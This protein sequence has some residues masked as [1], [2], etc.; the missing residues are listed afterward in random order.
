MENALRAWSDCAADLVAV[1]AGRQPADLVI[2][3]GQ[4]ANVH[5]R[6][7]L[8]WDVAIAADRKSVV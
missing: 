6:E 7:I 4:L 1:A 3:G 5:T 2:L 8:P